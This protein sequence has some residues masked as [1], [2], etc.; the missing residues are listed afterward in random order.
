M[1][2]VSEIAEGS[3]LGVI[4][5]PRDMALGLTSMM[6]GWGL[7]AHGDRLSVGSVCHGA[8]VEKA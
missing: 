8:V 1:V 7:P 5:I 3:L 4:E 6:E 2:E